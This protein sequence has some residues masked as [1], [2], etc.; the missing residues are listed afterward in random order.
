M[1]G[2][3]MGVMAADEFWLIP[4]GCSKGVVLEDPGFDLIVLSLT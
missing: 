2:G 3:W 4:S 1:L